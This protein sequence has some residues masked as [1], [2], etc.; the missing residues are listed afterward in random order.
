VKRE[1]RALALWKGISEAN[2]KNTKLVT[3]TLLAGVGE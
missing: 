3:T 1:K 2:K